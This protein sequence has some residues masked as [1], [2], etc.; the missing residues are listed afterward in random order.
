MSRFES[1][2]MQDKAIVTMEIKQE[3]A[4]TLSNG[5]RLNDLE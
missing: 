1:E 5:T 3:T 4:P 2:M